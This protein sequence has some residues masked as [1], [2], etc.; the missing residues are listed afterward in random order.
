MSMSQPT[1]SAR[2]NVYYFMLGRVRAASG[3]SGGVTAGS[4]NIDI[5]MEVIAIKLN[6]HDIDYL[7]VY[8]RGID[9]SC[10][11]YANLL[12]SCNL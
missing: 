10:S 9:L 11:P 12:L 2:C 4:A 8:D 1:P 5:M 7:V 3:R 6:V